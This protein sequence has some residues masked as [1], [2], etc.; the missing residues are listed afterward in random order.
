M[1]LLFKDIK[2]GEIRVK[3]ENQEDI[4]YLSNIIDEGDLIKGKTL[5][6]IKLGEKEQRNQKIIKKAVF[7]EL[8]A[9]KIEFSIDILKILGKITQGPEDITLGT[10]HSFNIEENT[11]ISIKKEKWLKFQLEK[12]KEA[13]QER[14]SKILIVVHDREEAYFALMKKYG[15]QILATINGSVQKK[16]Q[17]QQI[18]GNFYMEIIK[19]IKEY[20][21]RYKIQNVILAS[22]AFWKEDLMKELK[23]DELKG[24]IIL[25]TCSSVGKNAV[26]EVLKRP[27]AKEALKQDRISK[28]MNLVE[29]LLEEINKNNL[30]V[31]GIKETENAALA[32]AVNILLITDK[33]I[34]KSRQEN[35]YGK[36]DN[37]LKSVEQSKGEINIIS[38]DHDGGKKLNGLGGIGAIL[39]YKMNY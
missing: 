11:I 27:E 19:Q 23:D 31:Y 29:K 9:E 4:W 33:F 8:K 25:A 17:E 22:P 26:E 24:K 32:G 34:Q 5:R 35:N 10:Y 36:I 7:I 6:K 13:C 39:R 2:K 30:A 20:T 12:L 37:I 21:E 16:D 1:K 14:I 28:E 38:S 15:F 3:A 18:K